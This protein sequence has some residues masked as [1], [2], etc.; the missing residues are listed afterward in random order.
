[1][2]VCV[3]VSSEAYRATDDSGGS[4]QCQNFSEIVKKRASNV[5]SWVKTT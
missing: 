4:D 1:M 3:C 5:W 2:T